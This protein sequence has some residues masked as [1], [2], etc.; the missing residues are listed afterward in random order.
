MPNLNKV[1]LMGNLTR[2]PD[3]TYTAKGTA[4]CR[5]GLAINRK[6]SVDGEVREEV[7]FVDVV[8]WA[9]RGEVL[10]K[11]VKKGSPLYVE[12]RLVLDVWDDPTGKKRY[13]LKVIGETFEFLGSGDGSRRVPDENGPMGPGRTVAATDGSVPQYKDE[14]RNQQI[15]EMNKGA[16]DDEEDIPF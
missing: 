4:C 13:D 2:D 16:D 8:C 12:G 14:S 15:A 11:Y 10:A 1:M 9:K 5:I 6:F 3:L 7:T